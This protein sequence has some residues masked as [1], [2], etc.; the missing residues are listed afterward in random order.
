MTDWDDMVLVGTIARTHGLRG[1]VVVNS[2]TDFAEE[3]FRP[4]APL[5]ARPEG[6]AARL[7]VESARMQSG[8]PVVSFEGYATIEEGERLVGLEL[9][10][11]EDELLPLVEGAYYQHQLVGCSVETRS[12]GHVGRVARVD[13]GAGGSLLVIDGPQG[14][15]LVP[16]AAEICVGIDV[17]A[18]RITIEAPEGL[19]ELNETRRSG[20]SG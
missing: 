9:R 5:W 20:R 10:I 11:P 17:P 1:H 18:R 12:G 15:V 14:E 4:G 8:R 13:G 7:I 16:L 3:R 6:Q 19:L 2:E